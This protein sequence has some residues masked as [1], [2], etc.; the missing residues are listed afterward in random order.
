MEVNSPELQLSSSQ[1][2]GMS[3]YYVKLA[4]QVARDETADIVCLKEA[5]KN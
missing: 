1:E 3:F 2:S 5:E 4:S